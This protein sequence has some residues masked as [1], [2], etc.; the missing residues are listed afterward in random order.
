[1]RTKIFILLYLLISYGTYG[2]AKKNQYLGINILQLPALTLNVNYSVE[3]NPFF[4]PLVDIGYTFNYVKAAN[5]D[6]AGWLITSH[7]KHEFDY[8]DHITWY[9]YDIHKQSGGY[10]KLGGY[11][12]FRRALEKQHF[13]HVGIFLTNSVVYESG[14]MYILYPVE[15]IEP[16]PVNHAV[17]V[18]GLNV[19]AG[20]EF[21]IAKRLKSN[22]D[23]QISLPN[24]NY[25]DLY[26][27]RNFIPG[28]GFKDNEHRI[29]PMLIWNLKYRL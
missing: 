22:I 20:Y 21:S 8:P 26:G 1:M 10:L 9:S 16:T 17:I 7:I 11:F 28:M 3:I 19:A 4:T 15:H 2:Q 25:R 5:I 24:N 27:Y 23:F 18:T 13:A 14:D 29:F 12:N 6:W